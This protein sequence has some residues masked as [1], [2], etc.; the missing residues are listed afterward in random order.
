MTTRRAEGG[1]LTKV[2]IPLS[3]AAG[4]I[5]IAAAYVQMSISPQHTGFLSKPEI[6]ALG[7]STLAGLSTGVGAG[8]AVVWFTA[9]LPAA[10][11]LRELSF[12]QPE[13]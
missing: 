10:I 6:R 7:L 12:S 2:L 1:S 3:V 9:H 5:G 4:I 11:V 13:V 8:I